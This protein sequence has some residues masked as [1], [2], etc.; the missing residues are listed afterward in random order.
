[1]KIAIIRLDDGTVRTRI[2]AEM[3]RREYDEIT[4]INSY[5][6]WSDD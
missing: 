4:Y 2:L 5:L 6:F 3:Y 1:M